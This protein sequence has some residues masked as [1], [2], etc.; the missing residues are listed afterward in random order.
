MRRALVA[1]AI[2][3]QALLP[4]PA[5]AHA[6]LES[7]NPAADSVLAEEPAAVTLRFSEQPDASGSSIEV[8]GPDGGRV[9]AGHA[10]AKGADGLTVPLAA[11]LPNGVYAVR[12][13]AAT[14][15]GHVV[16][17]SFS[18]SIEAEEI[19]SPAATETA[20]P[21]TVEPA[22][23]MG[24][25]R[26]EGSNRGAAT[27]A[28]SAFLLVS[29]VAA[30]VA[31]RR[32]GLAS[33]VFVAALAIVGLGLVLVGWRRVQEGTVRLSVTPGVPGPNAFSLQLLD[34]RGEPVDAGT[35]NLRTVLAGQDSAGSDVPLVENGARWSGQGLLPRPGTW[36]VT[37][38]VQVEG[39]T[40]EVPLTLITRS[41]ALEPATPGVPFT[42]ASF[43]SGVALQVSLGTDTGD[44][45]VL[46]T[47]P[48]GSG[49]K[50]EA[51]QV[52][53]S[54]Q[55][56]GPDVLEAR[57]LGGGRAIARIA[58]AGTYTVDVVATTRDG[59]YFQATL[60]NVGVS[61]T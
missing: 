42:T 9:T 36:M 60:L 55:G 12:W 49:L 48:G 51:V 25:F 37:A 18:F 33:W 31:A 41:E 3:L 45:D 32:R 23:A 20:T 4:A 34:G 13:T 38:L 61:R 2:A 50:L 59:R 1:A 6:E 14:S 26:L 53:I 19:P 24:T 43:A 11:G 22:S 5:S 40:T 57:I 52:V 35:V 17:G 44:I 8:T 39:G 47:A 54:G 7:S 15:D 56:M 10:R 30:V 27:T 21:P 58:E 29:V 28:G 16:S 46:A